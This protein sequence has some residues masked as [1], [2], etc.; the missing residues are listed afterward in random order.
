MI[1]LEKIYNKGPARKADNCIGKLRAVDGDKNKFVL[2]DSGEKYK[3]K[4]IPYRDMR[5]EF[6]LF[7]YRYD[8]SYDG[9]I[10]KM[11]IVLPAV[12]NLDIT[13]QIKNKGL[14]IQ[15]NDKAKPKS[16]FLTQD[17]RPTSEN[18][19]II[20]QWTRQIEVNK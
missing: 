9:N 16:I 6:G 4:N 14:G 17:W 7:M 12:Y 5:R 15:P 8:P 1:T 3:S 11:C 13:P 18:N 19:T 10:R 2:Y 20:K